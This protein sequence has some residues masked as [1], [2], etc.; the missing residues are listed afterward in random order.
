MS[1]S[2]SPKDPK[3]TAEPPEIV[4][5]RGLIILTLSLV[6]GVGTG[7]LRYLDTPSVPGA[8]LA[9][10]AAFGASVMALV[11]LVRP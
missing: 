2:T 5:A 9:G 6:I 8:I 7:G 11:K 4:T 3:P 1:Q 10:A